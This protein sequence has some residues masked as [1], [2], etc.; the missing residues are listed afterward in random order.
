MWNHI[1]NIPHYQSRKKVLA[2]A[3]EAGVSIS[4]DLINE[5]S[6]RTPHLQ[7]CFSIMAVI[8]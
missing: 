4:L 8:C 2:L 7:P 1:L 5:I 6:S 3:H